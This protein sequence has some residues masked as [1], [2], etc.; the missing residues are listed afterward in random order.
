MNKKQQKALIRIILAA[1]L[2]VALHFVNVE[3]WITSKYKSLP[4][5]VT[6]L[7]LEYASKLLVT[8]DLSIIINEEC[9]CS[10]YSGCNAHTYALVMQE[11]KEQYNNPDDYSNHKRTRKVWFY[12]SIFAGN[13]RIDIF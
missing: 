8:T 9:V 4:Q 1:V 13:L 10:Q 2:L 6:D 3:G 12:S 11:S 5:F 7:R